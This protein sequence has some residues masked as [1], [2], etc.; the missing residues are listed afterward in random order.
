[1]ILERLIDLICDEFGLSEGDIGEE[2]SS[3]SPCMKCPPTTGVSATLPEQLPERTD[4][5][6]KRTKTGNG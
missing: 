2:A 1:M 5:D 4:A 3:E 6:E